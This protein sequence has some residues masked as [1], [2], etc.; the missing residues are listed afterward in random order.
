MSQGN[1]FGER[2]NSLQVAHSNTQSVRW[3]KVQQFYI[4][5]GLNNFNL[6]HI[7]KSSFYH[8]SQHS[9]TDPQLKPSIRPHKPD[10]HNSAPPTAQSSLRYSGIPEANQQ[11]NM[12][13]NCGKK[14]RAMRQTGWDFIL[15][16]LF[17][18]VKLSLVHV[19]EWNSAKEAV[20]ES[21]SPWSSITAQL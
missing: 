9:F 21:L 2:W 11:I 13:T 5:I 7:L 3:T 10:R 20:E 19:K 8:S 6:G 4:K 17:L 1:T 14:R 16:S 15:Q 12:I 18:L